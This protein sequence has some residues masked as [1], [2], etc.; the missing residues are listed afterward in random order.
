MHNSG[1]AADSLA[2]VDVVD[3]TSVKQFDL[4]DGDYFTQLAQSSVDTSKPT[5]LDVKR[6]QPPT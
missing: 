1:E 4:F 5:T 6:K 3:E 2:H